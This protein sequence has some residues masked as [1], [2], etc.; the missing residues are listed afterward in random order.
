MALA[1][2]Y[3]G[4]NLVSSK[5]VPHL[6]KAS[7]LF[8]MKVIKREK[9]RNYTVI[10]NVF[11]RDPNLSLKAKGFLATIMSLPDDWKFT[12]SGIC[13][14]LKES[15]TAVRSAINELKDNGYC[16]VMVLRNK[17]G[18]IVSWEYTFYENKQH[19]D[20]P[21]VENPDVDYPDVE[22]ETQI[23]TNNNKRKKERNT[24]TS[25]ENENYNDF[26]TSSSSPKQ[27]SETIDDFVIRMYAYYPSKCPK[28]GMSTGKCSKD[29]DR[30]RKLL[31]T[32]SMEQIAAVFKHEIDSKYGITYLSNFSTFLNNFPDPDECLPTKSENVSENKEKDV[33]SIYKW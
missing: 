3:K 4:I 22:N 18:I 26:S 15:D 33:N 32:Y 24:N 7:F 19:T 29:K 2:Y 16:S 6:T 9:N 28:R 17:K 31:K 12:V 23:I 30:I 27:T 1:K 5:V 20:N 11:L 10:S 21:D 8:K 25:V 14:T 13:E